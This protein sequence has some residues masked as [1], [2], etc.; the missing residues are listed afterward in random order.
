MTKQEAKEIA[1]ILKSGKRYKD[2]HYHSGY[3]YFWYTQYDK[4]F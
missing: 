3:M 4:C 1:E 2:G